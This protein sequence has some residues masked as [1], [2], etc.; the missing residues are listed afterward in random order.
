MQVL[1]NH[2]DMATDAYNPEKLTFR[3]SY[4]FV[5]RGRMTPSWEDCQEMGRGVFMPILQFFYCSLL[6][7]Q[8]P[9]LCNPNGTSCG[10]QGW[11]HLPHFLTKPIV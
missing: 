2:S 5:I 1:F 8:F 3:K 11:D 4:K 6:F 7:K 10:M 9:I